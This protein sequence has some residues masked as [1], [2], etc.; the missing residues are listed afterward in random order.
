V[1]IAGSAGGVLRRG[2]YVRIADGS[3]D[4]NHA[5]VLNTIGSAAGLRKP[6][7]T[8]IDDFGSPEEDRRVLDELLA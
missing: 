1:I 6:D 4:S 3:D 5:R 2:E 8:F 7:G